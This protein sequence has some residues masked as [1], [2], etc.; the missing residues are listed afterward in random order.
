MMAVSENSRMF[1]WYGLGLQPSFG[2]EDADGLK[3]VEHVSIK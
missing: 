2:V 3:L 1:S